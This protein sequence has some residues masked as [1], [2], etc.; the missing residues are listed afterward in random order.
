[1]PFGLVGYAYGTTAARPAHYL[2]GTA[3]VAPSSVDSVA[4]VPAAI[5][6]LVSA[7]AALYRRATGN[8]GSTGTRRSP[9]ALIDTTNGPCARIAMRTICSS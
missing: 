2:A 5:G 1:M 7:A 6:L 8:R 4:L 9:R 3:V